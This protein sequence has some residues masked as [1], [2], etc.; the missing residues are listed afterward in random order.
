MLMHTG[1]AVVEMGVCMLFL[2]AIDVVA[3]LLICFAS[4]WLDYVVD[5]VSLTLMRLHSVSFDDSPEINFGMVLNLL[6]TL[7]QNC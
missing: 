5:F 1:T 6:K 2:V 4:Y 3:P 7:H